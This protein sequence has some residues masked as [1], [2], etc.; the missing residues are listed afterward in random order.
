MWNGNGHTTL[1][2]QTW[3]HLVT[4]RKL[5]LI[6]RHVSMTSC[7]LLERNA[8]TPEYMATLTATCHPLYRF[9]RLAIRG[10][11]CREVKHKDY[12]DDKPPRKVTC[13]GATLS[14]TNPI[15][16]ILGQKRRLRRMILANNFPSYGTVPDNTELSVLHLAKKSSRKAW[17]YTIFTVCIL[18]CIL[19]YIYL[20]LRPSNTTN[21]HLII[22]LY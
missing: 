3:G 15:D 9:T 20:V 4:V 21:V 22:M 11:E 18:L 14:T 5:C 1:Q 10:L 6:R 19:K 8:A 17:M 12:D 13:P 2:K 7:F 16:S